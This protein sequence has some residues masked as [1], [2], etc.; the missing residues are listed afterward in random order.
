MLCKVR[1]YV[2]KATIKSIYYAIFHSHLSCIYTAWGQNLNRKHRIN[3]LQKKAMQIISFARYK[4]DTLPIFKSHEIKFFD[5]ISLCNCLFIYKHFISK[6]LPVF[7][8]VF[9]L[10]SNTHE[11]NTRFAIFW[12]NRLCNTSK[13]GT[14]AF[15]AS[16]TASW[17]YFPK[18]VS[19]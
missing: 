19:Q 15:S 3:L 8:H 17:N 16:A 14:N 9:I 7:S 4:A 1:H 13:Y 11:K 10:A 5:L 12:Q 2:N 18:R 6:S